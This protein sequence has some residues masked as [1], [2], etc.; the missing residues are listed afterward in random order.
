MG[1]LIS[2]CGIVIIVSRDIPKTF[3]FDSVFM[4][5]LLIIG[6]AVSF[7]LYNVLAKPVL[8]RNSP[9]KVTT[10]SIITGTVFLLPFTMGSVVRQDWFS[11]S[12]LGW[13]IFAF[14][15]IIT[16]GISYTLWTRGVAKIG[17]TKTQIYQNL[18]PVSAISLAV[19]ILGESLSLLQLL[20]AFVAIIGVFIARR[21]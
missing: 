13:F 15:I 4:G 19:P 5:N 17:A 20:G 16:A 12:H 2:L 7:A 14:C 10:Y 11:L 18:I 1:I 3:H 21:G 6:A 9:L 8:G